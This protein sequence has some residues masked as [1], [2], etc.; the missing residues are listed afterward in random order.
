MKL[1]VLITFGLVLYFVIT[2]KI[3]KTIAAMVGA[4]TLLTIRV[5][6]DPYEGLQK[7]IDINTIL[8]LIGMM[9][10]VRVMETSGIFQYIAIKTVKVA[11]TSLKK[12]F[13]AMTFIVAIVSSFI[14]NVT[15]ILIFV[16]VTFAITDILEI[17]PLPFVL[18][19]IFASNIGGTMTPIGDPPNIL[20]TSAARIPFIEFSK[21]MVPV[22]F[23]ILFLVNLSL[24]Y[25]SRENFKKVFSKEFLAEFDEKRAVTN[26]RR[27]ILSG[28]F[29]VLVISL[30]I[31]QKQLK[32]ESSIIGLIA[33]FF[34]LLLFEPQEITPF[35]EKVEWEVIFF[36][37]GLFVVTG[38][39]EHVGLMRDIADLLVDIS[40]GSNV[41]LSSVIVWVSGILSG[42]ID[43]IPFA[44][45][46][47][48]VI[49]GLPAINP[50][51]FSNI[52]PFWYALALGAC[53]GGNLTPVGASANVVGLSLLKKYKGEEVKFIQFV[54]FGFVATIISLVVSNIY[55]LILLKIL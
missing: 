30:F 39:M 1:I 18:G 15:T 14:D 47:I 54:K 7:S 37:L 22:N 27:F 26:R 51:A 16:P 10:F 29:M 31:F 6:P 9:I 13:F 46:M 53:L 4:L 20:I 3:N 43:N 17:D 33:G 52:T 24:V 40:K 21:Y 34:G 41:I 36:F 28:L 32:L 5:F 42:F 25:M 38:A 48:P 49:K 55:T 12:L 19:E 23:L 2:G 11:G 44:A 45:T 8:F 50:S 35:L